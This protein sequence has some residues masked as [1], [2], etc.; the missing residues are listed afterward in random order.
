[1]RI[2][3]VLSLTNA[4]LLNQPFVTT[5]T[6]LKFH[7]KDVKRGDLFIAFDEESIEDA[8]SHGAYGII[9]S[10]PT[11]ISDSEIAWIEVE[12]T[13][14]A[15]KRLLRF[16]LLKKDL[17]VYEV[18][19]IT[20]KLALQIVTEPKVIVLH[21][22]ILKSAKFLWDI[23]AESII[24]F[25][26]SLT[27]GDI[28]TKTIALP[29][30]MHHNINIVE[31]RLFET[32]FIYENI[33]YERQL[34][35]PLFIPY[36]EIL[37]NL[38]TALHIHYKLKKI[39]P[40]NH[41]EAVFINRRFERKDFGTSEKVLIFE[42]SSSLVKSE[43]EFLDK[44]AFWAKTLYLLPYSE[45]ALFDSIGKR[46]SLILYKNKKEIL[47][48]LQERDFN[49]ALLVGVTQDILNDSFSSKKRVSLFDF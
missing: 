38:F 42:K 33:F 40:I 44:E 35:S 25:S 30:T 28:F 4:K 13:H 32:S 39:V 43:I 27:Q 46:E 20:L 10:K 7:V 29:Q 47:P 36:L 37:L 24:L 17:V 34:I 12:N 45:E 9:L 2:E 19:E 15:L 18:D 23:D 11:R 26:P 1:M 22:D 48:L 31:Q 41:F 3:N 6:N 14:D 49:F 5:F 21:E 16:Q 8:I